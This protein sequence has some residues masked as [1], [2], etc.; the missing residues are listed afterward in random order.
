MEYI[1]TLSG[2]WLEVITAAYLLGM[3]LYGH[4]KGFIRLAVSAFALLI[5]LGAVHFGQPYVTE[6][7][8][9]DTP[10]YDSL[11]ASMTD[12]MDFDRIFDDLGTGDDVEKSDEWLAIERLPIP[13]QL[14]TKLADN[15]KEEVYEQ[16]GVHMF[17]DYIGGF[18]A[19]TVLKAA[20]YIGL[21]VVVFV[22]LHVVMTWLDI[23]AKLPILSGIN[24]LSGSVLGGAEA[25]VFIWIF[26]IVLTAL[27]GTDLGKSA[28]SQI[29]ASPWLSWIYD[30]NILSYFALGLVRG[31]V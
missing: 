14:K 11:R 12:G 19:D 9:Q 10:V 15:N 26:C 5:T 22:L 31:G 24:K 21:F 18:L 29:N 13:E 20:V 23:I 16:M 6:W 27:S 8:K 30:H 28:L 1:S 7:L 17:E 4:H 3:V 25:L 2:R